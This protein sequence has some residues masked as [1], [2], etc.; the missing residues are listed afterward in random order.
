MKNEREVVVR[1]IQPSEKPLPEVRKVFNS[2]EKK[3]RE[4]SRGFWQFLLRGM[5]LLV[6]G[7]ALFFF[8]YTLFQIGLP[9]KDVILLIGIP[10]IFGI[11][12]SY[13]AF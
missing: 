2:S 13:A 6:V 4:V 5:W 1:I 10:L 8:T 11:I 3:S 12:A 9:W 7:G